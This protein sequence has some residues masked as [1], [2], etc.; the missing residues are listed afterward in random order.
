VVRNEKQ[1]MKNGYSWQLL[2]G[3]DVKAQKL[4]AKSQLLNANKKI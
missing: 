2:A 3:L 1:A 4:I